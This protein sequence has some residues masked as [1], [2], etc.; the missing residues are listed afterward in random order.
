MEDLIANITNKCSTLWKQCDLTVVEDSMKKL[1]DVN[2][3]WWPEEA[4]WPRMN[5][6]T[7][8]YLLKT[9]ETIK[10]ARLTEQQRSDVVEILTVLDQ[11]LHPNDL[12]R[13]SCTII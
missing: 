12:I 2:K 5:V 7:V 10:L 11:N 6:Y 8:E 4:T 13:S 3:E 9:L 1:W